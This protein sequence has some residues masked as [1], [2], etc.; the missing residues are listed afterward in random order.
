VLVGEDDL[1]ELAPDGTPAGPRRG[2]VSALRVFRAAVRGLAWAG[3]VGWCALVTVLYLSALQA[4]R[5][6]VQEASA[7]AMACFAVLVGYVGAR[8]LDNMTRW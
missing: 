1:E 5:G 6:A 8:A 7:S 4:A 3:C 2:G